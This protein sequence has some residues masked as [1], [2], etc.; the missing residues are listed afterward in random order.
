MPP[1]SSISGEIRAIAVRLLAYISGIAGLAIV[2]AE[3]FQSP[4]VVA[5]IEPVSIPDW[6]TVERPAPAFEVNLPEA[7][8]DARYVIQRHARGGGRKDILSFGQ[9]GQSLRYMQLEIYRPGAELDHF[10]D[11]ATEIAIRAAPLGPAGDVRVSLPLDSKFG[12]VETVDFAIGR[13]GGGHCVGFVRNIGMPRMQLS[14]I[15]CSMNT[16]VDRPSVSCLL[17]RL[18]LLSSG[19]DQKFAEVF[20]RAEVNRKFCGQRDPLMYATPR[21]PMPEQHQNVRLRGSLASR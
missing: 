18:T 12:P 5:A 1:A 6:I 21:R 2:A 14:G 13:F 16:I 3:L 20:A 10:A 15:S 19:S 4:P 11:P 9:P 17:D 8:E 7:G